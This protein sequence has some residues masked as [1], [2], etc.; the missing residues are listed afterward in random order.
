M[1]FDDTLDGVLFYLFHN[2]LLA[3]PLIVV[4]GLLFG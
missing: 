4:L 2:V 1:K 3:A